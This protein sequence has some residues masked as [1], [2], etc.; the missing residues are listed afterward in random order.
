[1]QLKMPFLVAIKV[2]HPII[3]LRWEI[4]D[5]LVFYTHQDYLLCLE[6]AFSY[7]SLSTVA[8]SLQ[9]PTW[10]FRRAIDPVNPRH[11]KARMAL[12]SNYLE[13]PKVS[14]SHVKKLVRIGI[15]SIPFTGF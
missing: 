9:W 2:S 14:Q 8:L 13:V 6:I 5:L 12:L 7:W 10:K 15:G 1:M 3:A 4:V 11:E